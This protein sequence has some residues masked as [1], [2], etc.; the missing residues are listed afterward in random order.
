MPSRRAVLTRPTVTP[1]LL[2]IASSLHVFSNHSLLVENRH[3]DAESLKN[4]SCF[5][6][7]LF[8]FTVPEAITGGCEL[9]LPGRSASQPLLPSR[10]LLTRD[11]AFPRPAY[12]G[13]TCGPHFYWRPIVWDRDWG[14][15]ESAQL[16]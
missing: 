8:L 11:P 7:S 9:L 14:I 1:Q 10:R 16:M 12:P 6:S 15:P 3:S 5:I 13:R 2:F 4:S